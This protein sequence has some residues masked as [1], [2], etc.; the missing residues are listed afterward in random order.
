[1]EFLKDILDFLI[2]FKW[3]ICLFVDSSYCL[4]VDE[5]CEVLLKIIELMEIM[6]FKGIKVFIIN[7]RRDEIMILSKFLLIR[8]F[9]FEKLMD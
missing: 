6:N 4:E 9:C 8:Y 3:I 7:V 2:N 1:M 5:L